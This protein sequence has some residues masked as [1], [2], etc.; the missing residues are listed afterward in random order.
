MVSDKRDEIDGLNDRI[1]KLESLVYKLR[2][3]VDSQAAELSDYKE[4]SVSLKRSVS[5]LRGSNKGFTRAMGALRLA[6]TVRPMHL[7][8]IDGTGVQMCIKVKFVEDVG[9]T[10][11][12]GEII[13]VSEMTGW[14]M[15]P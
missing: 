7:A 11:D 10:D 5:S 4:A 1:R 6:Q 9:W 15:I 14:R 2:A 3:K 8:P 12:E 13:D